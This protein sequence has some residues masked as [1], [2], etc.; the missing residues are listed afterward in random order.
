MFGYFLS[1]TDIENC[2]VR[3]GAEVML[4]GQYFSAD[5]LRQ[6]G[7]EHQ[8]QLWTRPGV[9][10]KKLSG[11]RLGVSHSIIR[12]SFGDKVELKY[13]ENHFASWLSPL[14]IRQ[15]LEEIFPG[16]EFECWENFLKGVGV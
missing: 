8:Y 12:G 7:G 5:Y 13:L 14:D 4:L 10:I 3:S 1:K 11:I 6:E 15:Q 9:D 2:F 16:A